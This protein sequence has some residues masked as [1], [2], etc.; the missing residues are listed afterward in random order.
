MEE[1][2]APHI[3]SIPPHAFAENGFLSAVTNTVFSTWI[4]VF[5]VAACAAILFAARKSK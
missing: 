4:F 5:I 3:L 1:H 2:N